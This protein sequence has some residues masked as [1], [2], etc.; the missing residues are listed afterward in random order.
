MAA[1]S[2][3]SA[4]APAAMVTALLMPIV[5]HA[6]A[7]GAVE[8]QVEH[9][10]LQTIDEY[11]QAMQAGD[12]QQWTRYF[13]DNVR[14]A[15]PIS[16]QQGRQ[17]FADYYNWEFKTFQA[18][19][20]TK[21][22]IVSGRSAAVIYDWEATHKSSG[23]AVKIDTVAIYELGSSGRFESV[24]FYFDTAQVAAMFSGGPK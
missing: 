14:R 3:A 4:I 12:P 6:R 11:N 19:Y 15:S 20:T 16:S 7:A 17:A 5:P 23:Q 8:M 2:I 18:W 22:I 24:S 1:K 9:I 13:T 21:K 10:V